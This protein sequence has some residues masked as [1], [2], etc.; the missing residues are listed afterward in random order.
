MYPKRVSSRSR[1]LM[2]A[3]H[4]ARDNFLDVELL[5]GAAG[6]GGSAGLQRMALPLTAVFIS[7]RPVMSPARAILVAVSL[8]IIEPRPDL[9]RERAAGRARASSCTSTCWG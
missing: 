2:P 6:R 3:S 4:A 5:A 9:V 1:H 8:G 7:L